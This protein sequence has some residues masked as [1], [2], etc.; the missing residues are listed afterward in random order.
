MSEPVIKI[1]ELTRRFGA[2]TALDSVSLS[3]PRGAVYGLVGAN[4][5]GK[6]TL[7]K[8]VLGL[9]RAESGSVRVF[10]LDPVADPVAV[11]SRIGYLS[12]ENDV[13]GWMRVDELIRYSRAFYPAWDDAYAEELRQTFALDPTAKIKNLSKGQKARAGLLIALAYRPELLVLDE[14]S[15][16][17]DP[18]VRRDILGA[19]IRTIADDGRTVLF[20]SHLLE[21]V[22]QVADHVTMIRQGAIVLSAPLDEIRKSHRCLTV[23]FAE[24][25]PHPPPVAGVLRWDGGGQEWMAVVRGSSAALQTAAAGW[26]AN[27]VAERVPSLDEIFVAHVGM[28][29]DT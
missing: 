1:S 9:L 10:G 7:I 24:S 15:S 11:L 21:E 8:H 12:E 27:I 26:G 17:L 3:M 23:R 4:G 6:T 2:R 19:I 29:A 16:G 18:I 13:P 5:A 25:R 22:E 20:S 14:P 28:P